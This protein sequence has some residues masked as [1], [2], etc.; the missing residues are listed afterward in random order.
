MDKIPEFF[1]SLPDIRT[2]SDNRESSQETC[3]SPLIYRVSALTCTRAYGSSR[4]KAGCLGRLWLSSASLSHPSS[5]L[6]HVT[7]DSSSVLGKEKVCE[8][9]IWLCSALMAWSWY[10]HK[11]SR[12]RLFFL[13]DTSVGSSE[14][15]IV[16]PWSYLLL[17]PLWFPMLQHFTFQVSFYWDYISLAGLSRYCSSFSECPQ[18]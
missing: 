8:A 13:K 3:S 5:L 11:Q 15:P 7:S 17:C 18:N 16:S 10:R 12:C 14:P 6:L 4:E 2:P 1:W 9:K